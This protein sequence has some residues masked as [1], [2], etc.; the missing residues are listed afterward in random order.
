MIT[1]SWK[2]GICGRKETEIRFWLSSNNTA[3]RAIVTYGYRILLRPFQLSQA[4]LLGISF[5]IH[6]STLT[7]LLILYKV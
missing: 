3:R 6:Y 7:L 1:E 4:F 5:T 2:E